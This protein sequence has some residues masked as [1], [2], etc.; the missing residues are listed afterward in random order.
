MTTQRV[1]VLGGTG[2]T[3]ARIVRRLAERAV[4][5]R[6][7]SR[8]GEYPFVWEDRATWDA[9]LKGAS[10]AY[11]CY[12][13]DLAFPGVVELIAEFAQRAR[14][15][16]VN[17][18]VLLSGRG[19]E[20][21]QA[22]ERAVQTTAAEWTIVRSSW[23]AQ[24]FSEH[25]LLGPVLRGR[26]VLPAGDVVEPFIDLEDLAEL[27]TAALIEDGHANTVY[28]VTGPRL[29]SMHDVAAEI[30]AATGRSIDYAPSTAE[31]FMADLARDGIPRD[32]TQ[33]LAELFEEILDGRNAT[34][35]SDLE[36]ALG[37]PCRDFADYAR[38]T[39]TSNVWQTGFQDQR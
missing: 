2:R 18:L 21:A 32:D 13:P 23:F 28:E 6:V 35:T 29:L 16:G 8:Q 9:A 33:A 31:E 17:R 11:L 38:R 3:G 14:E 26:L 4:P 36:S 25:F 1:L 37:R 10:S 12:S 7:A 39:A 19:E 20:G 15:L 27:A 34:V 24:N 5:T 30:S 22:S